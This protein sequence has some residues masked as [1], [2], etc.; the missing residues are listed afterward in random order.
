MS[1][2]IPSNDPH[3]PA[4]KV[5]RRLFTEDGDDYPPE[6]RSYIAFHMHDLLPGSERQNGRCNGNSQRKIDNRGLEM[7]VA[8]SVVPCPFKTVEAEYSIFSYISRQLYG[9]HRASGL[10][11]PCSIRTH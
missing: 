3:G 11:Q 6:I 5:G 10:L 8:V 1:S 7:T 4:V 2:K 9:S